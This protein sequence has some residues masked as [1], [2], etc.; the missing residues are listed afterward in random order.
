MT[1]HL[2]GFKYHRCFEPVTTMPTKSLT[3]GCNLTDRTRALH[4]GTVRPKGID[5]NFI[6]L[7]IEEI[8]WRMLRYQ[9]FDVAEMSMSSYLMAKDTGD[10][11]FVAI[12]VFPSRYFR[13]S[14]IF[15]NTDAGID[16]PA[17]L[18]GK[19]VGV[20]EYQMT[21]PL[22]IRGIL[23]HEYGVEPSDMTWFQGG[24]EE[25]GRE[26]KLDLDLP[27]NVDISSIGADQTLSGM[28]E[29]GD[30][31]AL[32]SPRTPSSMASPSVDRLFP[33]FREVERDYYRKTE[34]FPIMHT[35]VM[36]EDVYDA[37]PWIARELQ[38][39]FAAA[40]D[41]CMAELRKTN[42]LHTTLPWFHHEF[43]S[44]RALMGEDFWPYGI[45][46]NESTLERMVEFSS[47]Q[48]LID[49][50]L[51]MDD[52]FAAETREAFKL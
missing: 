6:P 33:N 40:K 46:D 37:D 44:T 3:L 13:H 15:I 21:A 16:E 29:R 28:L 11:A 20:P 43:E 10:P 49:T 30:I 38:K 17:D 51:T 19:S 41:A 42:A 35:V 1:A 5:L 7:E 36:R 25:T 47:E 14:C 45:Q 23:E 22:W 2:W 31:D 12:P 9:E 27:E 4:D 18:R 24:I 8:F 52:L 32:F 34:H 50:R 26:E 48:G 39:A